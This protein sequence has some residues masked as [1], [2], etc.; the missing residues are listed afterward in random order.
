MCGIAGFWTPAGFAADEAGR[1]LVRMTDSIRSRGPDS[2]G[3]WIDPGSGVALGHRRLSILELSQ[4][5]AQPMISE[6]GRYVLVFNGEIYNHVAMRAALP[7]GAPYRGHSDTETLLRAF[8]VLG[9][10]DALKAAVGMF[11]F[12]CWDNNARVLILA[13]DRMGEK[14][15]YFGWQGSG[16][17]RSLLFGSEL[18]AITAHPAFERQIDRTAVASYLERLCVPGTASIWQGI[19]KVPPGTILR[20]CEGREG[21]STNSYWSVH[22]AIAAGKRD[23][24]EDTGTALD[25]VHDCLADAVRGQLLADVPLGAFLSGGIDSSLIAALMQRAGG[26]GCSTFSIGFEDDAYNEADYARAVAEHLGTAHTELVVSSSHAQEVIPRLPRFYDEPFA[27]SSQIPTFLVSQLARRH[28]TVALS[29]DG[30]DELFGG[31]TRYT[32]ALRAWARL[33]RAP[34]PVRGLAGRLGRVA[35]PALPPRLARAA[36]VVD[37]PDL[38]GFYRRFTRHSAHG[39]QEDDAGPALDAPGLD[40]A[41][42]LM[43]Q[44]QLGYLPDDILVKVDRAAMA[45]SLEVRAPYLD[46]RLVEASWRLDASVKRRQE[47]GTIVGKWPLRQLLERYV[48]R[49]L[50]DRPKH[51]FGIPV[52]AWLRGPL[53]NWADD[54][55]AGDRIDAMGLV[56]PRYVSATW[57]RHRSGRAD[58]TDAVW[59]LLMLSAWHE[60]HAG[61]G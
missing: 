42:R 36:M 10:D 23:P 2:S 29:G 47:G 19:G 7:A 11:A 9:I 26:G 28:V 33:S 57:Q 37:A 56:E 58:L 21:P 40:P 34:I 30:A 49:S 20:F 5:G 6:S 60:E 38:A 53:R 41:E 1:V 54:L 25:L 44:D 24:V 12:A 3:E 50:T 39:R 31:Y 59:A 61:P 4:A 8:D 18:K 13:R 52:G 15:L 43:A 46:H 22:E 48:P 51:G 16:S 45:V 14:P 32:K 55:L 17:Q 35:L 27:D